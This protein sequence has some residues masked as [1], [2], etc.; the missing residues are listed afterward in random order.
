[1]VRRYSG[2]RPDTGSEPV[3]KQRAG[4]RI[5]YIAIE[6]PSEQAA[7]GGQ[8]GPAADER[9]RLRGIAG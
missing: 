4:C 7:L 1:M 6:V 2:F 9:N 3:S 5:E 8:I